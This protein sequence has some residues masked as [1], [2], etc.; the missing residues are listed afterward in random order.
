MNILSSL[1]G[2]FSQRKGYIYAAIAAITFGMNPLFAKPLYGLGFN[3]DSVLLI[4]YLPAAVFVF[5]LLKFEKV[6]LK[7]TRL[8]FFHALI[9]GMLFSMCSLFLFI[10]YEMMDAGIASTLF[11]VYPVVTTLIMTLCFHEKLSKLII[12]CILLSL[13]GIALLCRTADGGFLT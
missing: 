7:L 10:S 6:S 12:S 13:A 2:F 5:F 9:C 3:A 1:T 8:E 4:R 11:F